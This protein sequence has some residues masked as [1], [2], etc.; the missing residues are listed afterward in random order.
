MRALKTE[1]NQKENQVKLY[2][3]TKVYSLDSIYAA[4]YV[5]IDRCYVYLDEN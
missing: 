2:L 1:I 3:N 4:A 5:F